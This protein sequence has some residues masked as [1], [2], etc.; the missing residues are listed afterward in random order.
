MRWRLYIFVLVLCA[1]SLVGCRPRGI[2]SSHEMR[3]LMEDLHKTDAL[4]QIYGLQYGNEEAR[5]IYYAQVLE[6][7]GI[8]QAQFD[9]SLVWYTAHPQLFDKI[10]PKV[11]ADLREE[12]RVFLLEHESELNL[13]PM[14]M[15]DSLAQ[16][17]KP[18]FCKA[19]L[20]SV[21]W[22]TQHGYIHTWNE[23]PLVQDTVNQFFPQIGVLGGGVVDSL[24]PRIRLAEVADN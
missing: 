15:T 5:Q 22:V 18:R 20:D 19:D 8:T 24:Q 1:V 3:M 13:T 2:L 9:S 12:E 4:L 11:L 10:Y 21:L 7:H 16:Q 6:K 17:P 23:R 14:A